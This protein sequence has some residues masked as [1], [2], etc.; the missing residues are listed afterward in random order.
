[1]QKTA[2]SVEFGD[3][4]VDLSA[5]IHLIR[6]HSGG[7]ALSERDAAAVEVAVRVVSGRV[8]PVVG[9]G[10]GVGGE[11]HRRVDDQGKRRVVIAEV[12]GDYVPLQ[13]VRTR[14]CDCIFLI[15]NLICK[16]RKLKHTIHSSV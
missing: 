7:V 15:T 5:K 8:A 6:A 16:R 13:T 9:G 12:E 3:G 1:M 11:D 4:N 2:R 10:T 14:D